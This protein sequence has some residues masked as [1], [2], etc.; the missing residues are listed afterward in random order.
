MQLKW[1]TQ[2]D[3][4]I[5]KMPPVGRGEHLDCMTFK[6]NRR[7]L[8]HYRLYIREAWEIM[9]REAARL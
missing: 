8:E 2:E 6:G 3:L 9:D 4:A 5:K 1:T 7:P